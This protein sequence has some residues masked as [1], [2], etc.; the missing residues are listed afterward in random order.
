MRPL[1]AVVLGLLCAL[2]GAASKDDGSTSSGAQGSASK[3]GSMQGGTGKVDKSDESLIEGISLYLAKR[4]EEQANADPPKPSDPEMQGVCSDPRAINYASNATGM[5]DYFCMFPTIRSTASRWQSLAEYCDD[6]NYFW[7]GSDMANCY[8]DG[9]ARLPPWPR[10][11]NGPCDHPNNCTVPITIK[12]LNL[13]VTRL[14]F[15]VKSNLIR[16]GVTY[17]LQWQDE[18]IFG[19][20][21]QDPTQ[22]WRP[23]VR[24]EAYVLTRGDKNPLRVLDEATLPEDR[25][26]F[27]TPPTCTQDQANIQTQTGQDLGCCNPGEEC[28]GG[29]VTFNSFVDCAAIDNCDVQLVERKELSLRLNRLDVHRFPYDEHVLRLNV[30]INNPYHSTEKDWW[31][32]YQPKPLNLV[33]EDLGSNRS[34]LE[35]SLPYSLGVLDVEQ[36]SLSANYSLI[37]NTSLAYFMD[38]ATPQAYN[39]ILTRPHRN[40]MGGV[41]IDIKVVRH[42]AL[43][44]RYFAFPMVLVG[45]TTCATPMLDDDAVNQISNRMSFASIAILTSLSLTNSLADMSGSEEQ[46]TSIDSLSIVTI[47]FG[48][49]VWMEALFSYAWWR[50]RNCEADKVW[51]CWF[52]R[53]LDKFSA[54]TCVTLYLYCVGVIL[55]L[56]QSPTASLVWGVVGFLIS[57]A[58]LAVAAYE[59]RR[60][61]LTARINPNEEDLIGQDDAAPVPNRRSLRQ[62]AVQPLQRQGGEEDDNN[63][64]TSARLIKKTSEALSKAAVWR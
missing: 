16:L 62:G 63:L 42:R 24:I 57:L 52:V 9:L 33:Y 5:L 2:E 34:T 54:V 20:I 40:G 6:G 55:L 64:S 41:A 49:L 36:F 26:V 22:T 28:D 15:D 46:L 7:D 51:T 18:R 56:P 30:Y 60:W 12:F 47:I 58:V 4:R 39:A 21:L 61:S 31:T 37:E 3:A 32:A 8:A 10:H 48:G 13:M 35:G 53:A 43:V 29:L 11:F 50:K 25:M 44:L 23:E 38:Q 14:D 45:L 1:W 19:T 59:I 27:V 17:A